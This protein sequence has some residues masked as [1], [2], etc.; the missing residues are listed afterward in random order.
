MVQT[1]VAGSIGTT[2]LELAVTCL[3]L[4]RGDEVIL[5]TFTII[6]CALAVL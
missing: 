2:T 1:P 4:Q 6:S 5:P 3:D